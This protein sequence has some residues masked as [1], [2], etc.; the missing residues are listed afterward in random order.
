MNPTQVDCILCGGSAEIRR[1][2]PTTGYQCR[3]CGTF[4]VTVQL[5]QSL[6]INNSLAPFLSAATR[7]ASEQ[8]KELL[9]ETENCEAYANA[10][11][12]TSVQ[13]KSRKILAYIRS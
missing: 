12:W 3:Q 2:G 6:R 8:G 10:Y 7:Q 5:G 9:L 4:R 11:R 1:G 13:D